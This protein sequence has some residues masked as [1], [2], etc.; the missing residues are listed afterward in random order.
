MTHWYVSNMMHS[1]K[2]N[3][4]VTWNEYMCD[5]THWYVWHDS[6]TP[7]EYIGHKKW[8]LVRDERNTDVTWLLAT[9]CD[10]SHIWM[11]HVTHMNESC[12]TS[13]L[14]MFYVFGVTGVADIVGKFCL[15]LYKYLTTH[16][17]N[18]NDVSRIT[19]NYEKFLVDAGMC[20]L[21]CVCVCVCVCVWTCRASLSTMRN[22]LL[23]LVCVCRC[24]CVCV[25]TCCASHSSMRNV[26]VNIF[27]FVWM[28]LCFRVAHHPQLWKNPCWCCKSVCVSVCVCVCVCMCVCVCVCYVSSITLN[29]VKFLVDAGSLSV[30][31]I[32]I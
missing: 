12:R 17:P 28:C 26:Y 16:E 27:V 14:L 21:V 20:V 25:L 18:P 32:H 24:V 13:I 11:R 29:L 22:F 23:M 6:F 1:Y 7:N 5:M 31:S 4:C 2:M 10:M 30:Y 15:P 9:E 3:T 19:L 8:I